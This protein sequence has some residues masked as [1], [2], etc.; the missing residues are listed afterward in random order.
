MR[1]GD[2]EG[3]L[4][5]GEGR[6]Q[7]VPGSRGGLERARHQRVAE[8]DLRR[9]SATCLNIFLPQVYEHFLTTQVGILAEYPHGTVRDSLD[10][11]VLAVEHD[12]I[13]DGVPDL[14]RAKAVVIEPAVDG[15]DFG[16]FAKCDAVL[17]ASGHERKPGDG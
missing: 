13:A 1:P 8:D 7:W 2:R 9:G 14:R 6:I 12:L 11:G 5:L 16:S 17:K 15:V 3:K 4:M 10:G